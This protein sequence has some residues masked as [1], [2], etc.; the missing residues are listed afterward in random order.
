MAE[1][2]KFFLML[3]LL[4][5]GKQSIT[6][7]CFD[8]YMELLVE[9]LLELWSGVPAFDIIEEEGLHNFMLRAMLIWTIHDFPGYGT[10]GGFAHQGFV[11]C[12]WYGEALGAEHSTELGKQT[13]RGCRR[14]LSMNHIFRSDGVKD[15]F[16]GQIENRKMPGRVSVE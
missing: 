14:W 10:V 4:I 11:A 1:Y 8:V 7:E 15:H 12:P 3:C 16:N 2:Q 6:S 13:Y 5:P 9:E